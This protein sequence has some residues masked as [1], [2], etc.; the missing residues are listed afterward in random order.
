MTDTRSWTK[1]PLIIRADSD[2]YEPVFE[3]LR[4]KNRQKREARLQSHILRS[5]WLWGIPDPLRVGLL[6]FSDDIVAA[7]TLDLV[8]ACSA[9]FYEDLTS[10][11]FDDDQPE[12]WT[13]EEKQASFGKPTTVG[14]VLMELCEKL[15][16]DPLRW[17]E[18]VDLELAK[19]PRQAT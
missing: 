10:A 9:L 8:N 5:P 1:P 6:A 19:Q 14:A 4:R 16:I 3:L 11:P 17:A 15:N 7:L 2:D 13:V 18:A 12:P